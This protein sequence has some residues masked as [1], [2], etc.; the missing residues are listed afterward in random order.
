MRPDFAGRVNYYSMQ[1]AQYFMGCLSVFAI[2]KG[3]LNLSPVE[4]W[5]TLPQVAKL[6]DALL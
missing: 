2:T 3:F 5:K 1:F 4:K 6:V